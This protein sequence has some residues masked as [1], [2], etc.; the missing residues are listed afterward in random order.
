M[1]DYI[2]SIVVSQWLWTTIKLVYL[3]VSLITRHAW[4]IWGGGGGGGAAENKKIYGF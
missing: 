1:C 2:K 3:V 4:V